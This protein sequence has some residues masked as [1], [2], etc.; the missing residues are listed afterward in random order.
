MP[1]A[2]GETWFVMLYKFKMVCGTMEGSVVEEV[3]VFGGCCCCLALGLS[4]GLCR[5]IK[6]KI[7]VMISIVC[8]NC[9]GMAPWIPPFVA[10]SRG[11][12]LEP[13]DGTT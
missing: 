12:L 5:G 1:C 11:L 8:L 4:L 6:L 3:V 10:R 2:T 13:K 9:F 7:G